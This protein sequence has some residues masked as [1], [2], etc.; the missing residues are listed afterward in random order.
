MVHESCGNEDPFHFALTE[1][2]NCTQWM[3]QKINASSY[4]EDISDRM[5][6]IKKESGQEYEQIIG[7][8]NIYR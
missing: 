4:D 2:W 5:E 1:S 3:Y 7:I 8:N 6:I